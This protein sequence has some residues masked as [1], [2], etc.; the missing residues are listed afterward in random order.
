VEHFR[1]KAGVY[2]EAS[3]KVSTPGYY[4]LAYEWTNLLFACEQCNRR[5]KKNHFPL[6]DETKRARH[7][8]HALSRERPVF[9]DPTVE[10]PTRHVSFRDEIAYGR[11]PRGRVTVEALQLNRGPLATRR[12]DALRTLR[13]LRNAEAALA[14]RRGKKEREALVEVRAVLRD[15]DS[16]RAEY[17]AML[18]CAGPLG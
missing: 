2:S 18:R 14:L 15:L 8:T 5:G 9:V 4:W 3:G 16:E 17:S 6:L 7:H 1:P 13:A 11:T 12:A 10:D